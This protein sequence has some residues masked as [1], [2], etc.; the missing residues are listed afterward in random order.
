[1]FG[2]RTWPFQKSDIFSSFPDEARQL[3]LFSDKALKGYVSADE[4]E[5]FSFKSSLL[6]IF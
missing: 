3:G 6:N 4:L 5:L 2:A 1:M